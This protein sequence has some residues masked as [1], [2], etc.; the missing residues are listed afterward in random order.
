MDGSPDYIQ[1]EVNRKLTMLAIYCLDIPS[2]KKR[3]K[4]GQILEEI[5]MEDLPNLVKKL[6]ANGKKN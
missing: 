3:S 5:E 4:A 1:K 6:K 2:P